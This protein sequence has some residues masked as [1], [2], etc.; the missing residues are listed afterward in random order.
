[1]RTQILINTHPL[2]TRVAFLEDGVLTDF[3]VEREQ[4]IVGSLY[5]GRV[6]NVLPGMDAA[7]V[8]IGQARNAFIYVSDVDPARVPETSHRRTRYASIAEALSVGEDLVV[9]VVRPPVGSKGARVTTRLSLQGRYA[10]LMIVSPG[11]LGVSRQI[12]DKGEQKRLKRLADRLRPLGHGLILRTEAEG[13]GEDAIGRDVASLQ[14]TWQ[15]LQELSQATESPTLLHQEPGLAERVIR[16]RTAP[17]VAEIVVDARADFEHCR[18]LLEETAPAL[19]SRLKLV[20]APPPLFD[21]YGVEAQVRLALSRRVPLPSGGHLTIDETEALTSIDV[22]TGSFVGSSHLSDTVLATN[23]EA[24]RESARQIRLRDLGGIIIIDFIDMSRVRDRVHVMDTLEA[25]LQR[26]R[27]HPR[28]VHLSP[29]GLVELTRRRRGLSL[30]QMMRV[31]CPYCD[32]LG[33]VCSATTVA[34]EARREVLRECAR[35]HPEAV[36]LSV[37]PEVAA[38]L[39]DHGG[40][41]MQTLEAETGAQVFLAVSV[42]AH[43]EHLQV[44]AGSVADLVPRRSPPAEDSVLD[45]LLRT[46]PLVPH[47]HP[48]YVPRGN[49]LV[50]LPH[51]TGHEHDPFRIRVTECG[52]WFCLSEAVH[53]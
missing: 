39:I 42:D 29:L 10:V 9:Q 28:I 23:L 2:E 35:S 49:C 36:L 20:E 30:S 34:A 15:Q 3:E 19:Q 41:G 24:I 4:K 1:M 25:E 46:E 27:M 37:H 7:F 47:G 32:G 26:D 40:E 17:D 22:D 6:V 13:C 53:A 50:R 51:L 11:H 18:R 48:L 5:K 14:A 38:Q 52:R 31:T 21:A 12:E 8:D 33:E 43:P 44:Q 45:V 16:D